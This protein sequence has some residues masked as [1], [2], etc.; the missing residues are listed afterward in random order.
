MSTTT[1]DIILDFSIRKPKPE[2]VNLQKSQLKFSDNV[3]HFGAEISDYQLPST[4]LDTTNVNR[5]LT[6]FGTPQN[7]GFQILPSSAVKR[8]KRSNSK[9]GKSSTMIVNESCPTVSTSVGD[10]LMVDKVST[11]ILDF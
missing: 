3:Q 10:L 2:A 1:E 7:F 9:N 8:R 5:A 4:I 6:Y 11:L